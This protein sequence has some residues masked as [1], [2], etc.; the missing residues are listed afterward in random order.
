MLKKQRKNRLYA[1]S[2]MFCLQMGPPDQTL[3]ARLFWPL[4]ALGKLE[5]HPDFRRFPACSE[6]K[7][8]T[9]NKLN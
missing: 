6:I 1:F 9:Q 2:S 3:R 4:S 7:T 5:S 8:V